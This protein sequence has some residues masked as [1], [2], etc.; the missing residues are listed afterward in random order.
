VYKAKYIHEISIKN[1]LY[2]INE[3]KPENKRDFVHNQI[4]SFLTELEKDFVPDAAGILELYKMYLE[5]VG[6]EYSNKL[7]FIIAIKKKSMFVFLSAF[8]LLFLLLNLQVYY[9]VFLLVAFSII[10]IRMQFYEKRKRTYGL[11][12]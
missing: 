1:F 5:P 8:L 9:Y 3:V 12:Y 10:F 7:G 4:H 11:F 2:H 6:Q